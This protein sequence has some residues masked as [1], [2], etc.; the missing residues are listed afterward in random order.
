MATAH[1]DRHAHVD[2][3]L[4]SWR[5][6]D[7]CLGK[8]SFVHRFNVEHPL[9]AVAEAV[10][11]ESAG[12]IDLAESDVRGFM[13]A[14]QTCDLVRSS[15]DRPYVRLSPLVEV[16]EKRLLEIARGYRPRYAYIPGTANLHL[17]ADLDRSM[18]VE[19]A[20]I[21]NWDRTPGC[22][23]DEE[24]RRL[25]YSLSRSVS[26]PALPD[27][28]VVLISK[29]KDRLHD[30]HDRESVEGGALRTL[31]EIRAT[32]SPNWNAE[33]VNVHFLFIRGEQSGT[34]FQGLS[35]D[36]LLE[37]WL[38]LIPPSQ[39]FAKVTG[40]VDTMGVLTAQDY[41]ESTPLDFDNLTILSR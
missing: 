23:D 32:A 7:C 17:V 15:E 29:L 4:A 25:A 35:W 14:T 18:T 5:L 24:V 19:K 37:R 33:Q 3:A 22:S 34:A 27:D 20:V 31:L 40:S 41:I 36:K 8:H 13:V 39:R 16:D 26:R 6:G 9:T 1:E 11:N 2:E 21:A 38:N 28:F 30:K 12:E 10:T